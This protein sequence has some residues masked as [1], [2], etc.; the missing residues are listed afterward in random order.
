M[1][2]KNYSDYLLILVV[3]IIV[4]IKF[5]IN[6]NYFFDD[7]LIYARYIKN[8]AKGQGLVY[9]KGDYFNGLTSPLF[10]YI[11]LAI[12][13][14]FQIKNQILLNNGIGY[15]FISASIILIYLILKSLRYS[16][17]SIASIL[18][19]YSLSNIYLFLGMET[20]L[21]LFLIFL[22]YYFYLKE[23]FLS[24][25]IAAALL[26]ITRTEGI[27]FI[28]PT[29]F[30]FFCER[31]KL[32]KEFFLY[33]V[34][35][36]LILTI[37]YGFNFF[38]YG[39]ILPDSSKA[40]IYHGISHYWGNRT[41]F[42]NGTLELITYDYKNRHLFSLPLRYLYYLI[43][44]FIPISI[45]FKKKNSF[46][47]FLIISNLLLLSFYLY[48]NVPL[49]TW[50]IAPI[51]FTK[52][53]F[54]VMGLE[55]FTDKI[56]NAK[57]DRTNLIFVGVLLFFVSF[58][59]NYNNKYINFHGRE[60]MQ[61]ERDYIR[62]SKW[63]NANTRADESIGTAEIG[64]IGYYTDRKMIDLCGL[65]SKDNAYYLSK[66]DLDSWIMKY[67]PDYI[68]FHDPKWMIEADIPSHHKNYSL[69]E[70]FNFKG[71]KMY[72]KSNNY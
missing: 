56:F 6:R 48:F 44:I 49:Y 26:L 62:I 59:L 10:T 15:F 34:L 42:I 28:I 24:Y 14:V 54:T 22:L 69:V 29:V 11:N 39:N 23:K 63:I 30:L 61:R 71:Y 57:K 18:V 25:F 36:L 8:F 27:F 9:N 58:L 52:I 3:E 21:Y 70:G 4:F 33:S 53:Y 45:L 31:K 20:G 51:I 38:Y 1:K 60:N 68:L 72:K 12:N 46:D 5:Y 43:L 16:F 32:K 67:K 19:L 37:H 7:T 47:Y 13:S 66:R 41:N 64:I 35:S 2:K 55:Y 65:I 50:Y 17:A 40:K